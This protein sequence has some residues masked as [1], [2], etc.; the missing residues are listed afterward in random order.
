VPRDRTSEI[1]L[2]TDESAPSEDEIRR[3]IDEAGF[4]VSSQTISFAAEGRR[5]FTFKVHRSRPLSETQ[6][7]PLLDV[8]AREP[9]MRRVAW[10]DPA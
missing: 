2:E 3:K 1:T 7:P 9:G 10:R 4:S 8:L 5:A 6:R